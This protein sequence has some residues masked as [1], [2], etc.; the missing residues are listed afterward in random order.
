[1]QIAAYQVWPMLLI[2][3]ACMLVYIGFINGIEALAVVALAAGLYVWLRRRH[4]SVARH[5]AN[6]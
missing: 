2:F 5:M 3:V 6:H 1:M 4:D